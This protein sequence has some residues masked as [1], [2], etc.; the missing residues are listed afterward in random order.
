[1]KDAKFMLVQALCGAVVGWAAAVILAAIAVP[2]FSDLFAPM[3]MARE[4]ER[5]AKLAERL[6]GFSR[7]WIG[8]PIL[9]LTV[10]VSWHWT[11]RRLNPALPPGAPSSGV[12][13]TSII[14]AGVA[15]FT[16]ASVLGETVTDGRF[17]PVAFA[18]G[19]LGLAL[20]WLFISPEGWA[21]NFGERCRRVMPRVLGV[22][23]FLV[24]IFGT[25][26]AAFWILGKFVQSNVLLTSGAI[27]IWAISAFPIYL[28]STRLTRFL[29][30]RWEN[31][32][33]DAS[34]PPS[35]YVRTAFLGLLFGII[36]IFGVYLSNKLFTFL[37]ALNVQVWTDSMEIAF[38]GM[39]RMIGIL[40]FVCAAFFSV[41]FGLARAFSADGSSA[42]ERLRRA[43]PPIIL[44][45]VLAVPAGVLYLNAILKHDWRAGGLA[46][47]AG[48]SP[49]TPLPMTVITL[50]L[51]SGKKRVEL[52]PWPLTARYDGFLSPSEISATE[53]NAKGLMTFL[54]EK[55]ESRYRG[56]ALWMI[57][58]IYAALWENEKMM[59]AQ[60]EFIFSERF[61]R[62]LP[63]I[64]YALRLYSLANFSPITKENKER[65]LR[66]SDPGRYQI[67]GRSA[68]SLARAWRRFGDFSRTKFWFDEAKRLGADPS[69]IKEFGAPKQKL[70]TTGIVKGRLLISAP[71][72]TSIKI[73]L[74]YRG[75]LA[76]KAPGNISAP[77]RGYSGPTG[78]VEAQ[79]LKQD[80]S[81]IFKNIS[82]GYYFISFLAPSDMTQKN[83]QATG[84]PGLITLSKASPT[85][86]LGHI[87]LRLPDRFDKRTAGW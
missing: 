25:L 46:N 28:I 66:F 43:L 86:D 50:G 9:I 61:S 59:R 40:V 78:F 65:L 75:A 23:V 30:R 42:R 54:E 53:E 5:L 77:Y 84:H 71:I 29:R 13:W 45:T 21:G 60:D 34:E 3:E 20:G 17:N 4:F 41:G 56:A 33:V 81:F 73:G 32:V 48:L 36:F 68:L 80:G 55:K 6:G 85:K 58:D 22:L 15:F 12:V 74:F 83:V 87:T 27:L 76:F 14:L 1:M 51:S 11:A 18:F 8:L 64:W 69:S 19:F 79:W 38:G 37:F 39:L 70:L 82:E 16:G 44:A 47:T 67:K 31:A 62:G 72:A 63:I 52:T 35:H 2:R 57:P 7:P 26:F 10:C 24:L 49:E